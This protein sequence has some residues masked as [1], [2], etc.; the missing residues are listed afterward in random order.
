MT[1]WP[2]PELSGLSCYTGS[3]AVYLAG[4]GV[5]AADVL[6]DSIRL[7]VRTDLPGDAL[8]F[9]HH[10]FALDVLPGGDRLRYASAADP[11]AGMACAADELARHGRVIVV[12]DNAELPWSPSY[13]IGPSA[14]HWLVLD[15]RD[16]DRWHVLDAFDGLLPAGGQ[17]PFTGWLPT[18]SLLAALTLPRHWSAEQRRRNEL[19]FGF[20][21]AVPDGP[22]ATWLRREPRTGDAIPDLPGHWLFGTADALPFL[23][24]YLGDC[25]PVRTEPV[26]DDV[27]AAARHHV[28]RHRRLAGVAGENA[29]RHDAAA[30]AW[31]GLPQA[32]RFAVESAVRGRSRA[33][34]VRTTLAHLVSLEQP[35]TQAPTS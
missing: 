7:A 20:P 34:L 8:A 17:E 30:H 2:Y 31:S 21:V 16:G 5:D 4:E 35:A 15:G 26:L 24:E 6:A 27:W 14:P 22:G 33:S 28:F 19:A 13:G 1:D 29:Q 11:V 3:L 9:S 12:V 18:A 10:R 23:V 25:S 32:V